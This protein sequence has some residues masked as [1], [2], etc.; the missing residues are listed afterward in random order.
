VVERK[1]P[2]RRQIVKI[3]VFLERHFEIALRV[4]KTLMELLL[5]F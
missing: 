5:C 1:V 4:E 3:G 2:D